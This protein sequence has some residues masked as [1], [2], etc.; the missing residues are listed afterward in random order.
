[1]LIVAHTSNNNVSITDKKTVLKKRQLVKKIWSQHQKMYH[2]K[3]AIPL[4]TSVFQKY[5]FAPS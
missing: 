5:A 1:M 3:G 4:S 2:N